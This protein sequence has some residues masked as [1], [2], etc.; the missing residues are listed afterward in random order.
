MESLQ[1]TW[2]SDPRFL[3]LCHKIDETL[4]RG[5]VQRPSFIMILACSGGPDSVFAAHYLHY[6]SRFISMKVILCYFDH[7]WRQ[8]AKEEVLFCKTLAERLGFEFETRTSAQQKEKTGQS[9][10]GSKE[11]EARELRYAFLR[12]MKEKYHADYIVLGH[13]KDDQFETFF[14]RMIRGTSLQGLC[15]M[16]IIDGDLF[17][18]LLSLSKSDILFC[19]DSLH[20]LSCIDT[21]NLDL[22]LLRNR[23]RHVLI[24]ACKE[25]DNRSLNNIEQLIHRLQNAESC[26]AKIA[27]E[28]FSA[29]VITKNG[30]IFLPI[31]QL[32]ALPKE[33]QYR[34]L[35]LFFVKNN[36]KMV[37]S[38]RLFQEVLRFLRNTKSKKHEITK[39]AY[40]TKEKDLLRFV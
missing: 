17:R 35:L 28:T 34:V 36:V 1:K 22:S 20:I 15:G 2:M 8:E 19:L 31:E 4:N 25:V 10:Q 7:E 27:A 13:H 26:L 32:Y 12:D 38:E 23:V 37:F 33:L 14:I 30:T 29:L 24:P 40:L 9:V 11:A 21:S 39:Y 3:S 16:K 18:P 5:L 6:K